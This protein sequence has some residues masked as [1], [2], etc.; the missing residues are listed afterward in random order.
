MTAPGA[1]L[2]THQEQGLVS[3]RQHF[4]QGARCVL[5]QLPTGTGKT[6]MVVSGINGAIAKPAPGQKHLPA[7]QRRL[8]SVAFVVPRRE[9]LWQSGAELSA[10]G[11]NHKI[12]KKLDDP[13]SFQTHIWCRD[14][15]I[16]RVRSG[17]LQQWPDLI[18]VDEAHLGLKQWLEILDTA[19]PSTKFLGVTATPERLDR[20]DLSKMWDV[21]IEGDQLAYFVENGFLKRPWVLS[22]PQVDRLEGLDALKRNKAGDVSAAKL[23]ELY[24][25]RARGKKIVYGNEIEHYKIHGQGRSYLIFCR[26][27]VQA[28][29]VAAEFTAQGYKTEAIDGTMTDN[30]RKRKIDA[31]KDGSLMG[32]TTVDLCTYGLDVPKISCLIMLRPT[33]SVALF[34]QMIGRGLRWDGVWEQCLVLDHVGNCDLKNHGHPL[35]P[36]VWNWTGASKREQVPE[37]AIEK[38]SAVPK[39]PICYGN[40]IPGKRD[41]KPALVCND[42]NCP[43]TKEIKHRKDLKEVDGYLVEILPGEQLVMGDRLLENRREFQDRI[44]SAVTRFRVAWYPSKMGKGG[45]VDAAAVRDMIQIAYDLKWKQPQRQVYYKLVLNEDNTVCTPLLTVIAGIEIEDIKKRYHDKW[46]EMERE[47][48]EINLAR[49]MSA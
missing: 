12:V 37:G 20:G 32:L 44:N 11:I 23:A 40:L 49:R 25:A 35:E 46:I 39:C 27:L 21:L 43:G 8:Q 15:F 33:E 31:V 10:W 29:E 7:S 28:E 34:F 22:V 38:I 14:T 24:K 13:K 3:A 19:P 16:R 36:R 18:I 30:V 4:G 6:K 41:G 48:I 5:I 26:S 2:W 42:P 47:F 17:D 45:V 1:N 9:L